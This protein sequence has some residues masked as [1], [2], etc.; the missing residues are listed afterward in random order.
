[1]WVITG[2]PCAPGGAQTLMNRQ[3]SLPWFGPDFPICGCV[4]TAPKAVAFS[5]VVQDSAGCGGAQRRSPTGG[6]AYGM[7]SHSFTPLM[8]IPQTGP[9]E[10]WTVVPLSQGGAAAAKS[11]QSATMTVNH[12]PP[13]HGVPRMDL[14]I[15]FPPIVGRPRP[16]RAVTWRA[17]SRASDGGVGLLRFRRE[18]RAPSQFRRHCRCAHAHHVDTGPTGKGRRRSG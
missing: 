9:L 7:P 4:Q 11:V 18:A 3:S 14:F 15:S 6:A 8:T 2:R 16:I 17:R 1:M 12:N 5:V 10:V 13:S